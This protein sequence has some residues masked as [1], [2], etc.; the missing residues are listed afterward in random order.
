MVLVIPVVVVNSASVIRDLLYSVI[1][2]LF[3]L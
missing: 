1:T 3:D 2:A